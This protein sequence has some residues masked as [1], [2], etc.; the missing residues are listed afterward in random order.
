L[1]IAAAIELFK[2][3]NSLALISVHDSARSIIGRIASAACTLILNFIANARSRLRNTIFHKSYP[4]CGEFGED[5]VGA[6]L[7]SS[8]AFF[9]VDGVKYRIRACASQILG[10]ISRIE[11]GL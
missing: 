11:W 2:W 7:R 10:R 3:N 1:R 6:A 4:I 5:F 9:S 8:L